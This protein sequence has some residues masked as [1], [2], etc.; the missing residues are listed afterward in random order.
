ML[1]V[2][3]TDRM[4]DLI[5]IPRLSTAVFISKAASVMDGKHDHKIREANL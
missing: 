4:T 3:H 1:E 5:S 2:T